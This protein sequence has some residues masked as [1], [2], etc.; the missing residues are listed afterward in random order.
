MMASTENDLFILHSDKVP[1]VGRVTE[2][3]LNALGI[4]TVGELVCLFHWRMT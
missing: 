1:G 4:N 2:R 3:E